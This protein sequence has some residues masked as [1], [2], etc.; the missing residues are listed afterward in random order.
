MN[1]EKKIE[2]LERKVKTVEEAILLL[3]ELTASHDEML[4]IQMKSDEDLNE[5][6]SALI[7]AQIRSEDKMEALNTAQNKTEEKMQSLIDL[8]RLAHRRLDELEK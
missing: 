7:D 6:I 4:Y 1:S 8:T 3:S 2:R 5:K